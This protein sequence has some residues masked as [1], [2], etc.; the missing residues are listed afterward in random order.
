MNM[1]QDLRKGI[2]MDQFEKEKL[3]FL[4]TLRGEFDKLPTCIILDSDPT[5][6]IRCFIP[7]SECGHLSEPKRTTT[8]PDEYDQ[9]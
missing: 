9:C 1:R 6:P 7:E 8:S 4:K 2:D 3:K 5:T